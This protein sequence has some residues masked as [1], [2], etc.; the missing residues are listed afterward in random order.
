MLTFPGIDE[1]FRFADIYMDSERDVAGFLGTEEGFSTIPCVI[2]LL[3]NRRP[4]YRFWYSDL[5]CKFPAL[6]LSGSGRSD[7]RTLKDVLL[8]VE[9]E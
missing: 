8:S 4:R 1:R 9:K 3:A 7:L 2:S 5:P 6:P